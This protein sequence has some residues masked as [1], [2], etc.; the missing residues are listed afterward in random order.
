[1]WL[2]VYCIGCYIDM[3]TSTRRNELQAKMVRT[4]SCP[5]RQQVAG[6][7]VTRRDWNFAKSGKPVAIFQKLYRS[8]DPAKKIV[9][10]RRQRELTFDPQQTLVP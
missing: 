7:F 4:P 6:R 10:D 9:T 5:K 3:A 8:E 2:D 1:L